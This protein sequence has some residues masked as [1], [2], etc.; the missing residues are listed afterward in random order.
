[1]ALSNLPWFPTGARQVHEVEVQLPFHQHKRKN[2]LRKVHLYK[3]GTVAGKPTVWC[4]WF[5]NS[6]RQADTETTKT[7]TWAALV[8]W[9]TP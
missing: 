5:L 8:F 9:A 7:T 3:I 2:Q 4:W 6:A 1:M